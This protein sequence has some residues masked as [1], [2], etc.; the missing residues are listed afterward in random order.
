MAL[1]APGAAFAQEGV[2]AGDAQAATDESQGLSEIVVTARKV[3]ENLQDIP[4]AVTAF[5]GEQLEQQNAQLLPDIARLAPGFTIKPSNATPTAI[6]LQIRGQYQSDVLATLDPSVGTYV[7]GFYW[8]RAYGLA[9]NLL[10]IRSAQVLRGPQGTLF[11]RNTTGGALILETNDP[12]FRG[13]SGQV[14]ATYGRFDERS[15]TAIIN[16]PIV[17]DVLALRG[18]FSILKRD[19]YIRESTSGALIGDRDSW[20]GRVKALVRPTETFSL[21]LSAE[22][23]KTDALMEPYRLAFVSTTS[24][25]NIQAGID[26]FGPGA[27]AVRLPQGV[28]IYRNYIPGAQNNDTVTLNELPRSFV[29][30]ETYTGTASLETFFGEVKFIG[31]YRAIDSFASTDLDGSPAN[32]IRSRGDQN[33]KQYSGELQF[34]GKALNDRLDFV[35]GLFYFHEYGIDQSTATTLPAIIANNPN[36]SYGDIDTRSQGV[37]GQATWDATEALSITAGLRYSVEDKGITIRNRRMTPAG[38]VC[39]VLPAVPPLCEVSREDDYAGVSYTLGADYEFS[40][41]TLLYAK[42]SKGFRS[43]GQNLRAQG[44]AGASFVPFEPEV[45]YEHEVGLK[46]EFLDRRV[47][48]NVA[49][50]YNTVNN[51]QRSTL[52]T[53]ILPGGGVT[54]ATIVGNAGKVRTYGGEAELT[55]LLFDGFTLAGTAG[56]IKPKYLEYLDPNTGADRSLERFELVPEWTFSVAGTYQREFGSGEL[57]LRADY[58]WEDEMALAPNNNPADAL[59]SQIVAVST[60]PAGGQ[61]NAR[62][63]FTFMDGGLQ[64]AAFGRNILNRRYSTNALL[65]PAPLSVIATR[66]NEPATYGVTATWRFGAN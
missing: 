16:L 65:F 12:H 42:S 21:L 55:A 10:D 57:L 26:A 44:T 15:G 41:G 45:S 37:Y 5:T 18:G 63:A 48:F 59:N 38:I 20:T 6:N 47:R 8:A 19:G 1:C 7:D 43:G 49:A 58:S 30:A 33:L 53:S 60:R 36:F 23:H 28:E 61:L 32:I 24:P 27:A 50:F 66:R 31:G 39:N 2:E 9:A 29:E 40:D 62:A 25:A 14:S 3:E 13:V 54:Q 17:D 4:V 56:L 51:V 11:G 35:G 52:V 64:I 34:T 46:S 22:L